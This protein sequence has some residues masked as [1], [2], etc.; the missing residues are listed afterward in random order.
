M[1]NSCVH[2]GYNLNMARKP[3]IDESVLKAA[4]IGLEV[5]N[6]EL[7]QQISA[8]RQQLSGSEGKRAT[9]KV[10][11]KR[12]DALSAAA[13]KNMAHATRKRWAAYRKAKR[14]NK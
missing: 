5:K 6:G 14:A 7:N 9:S 8:I 4:L 11:V 13:R 3:F 10:P 12:K 2:L 1:I